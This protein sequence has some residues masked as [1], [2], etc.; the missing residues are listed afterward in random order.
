MGTRKFKVGK[1]KLKGW[2]DKEVSKAIENRKR[3]NR[4]QRSLA[5]KMKKYGKEYEKDWREAW[6]EYTSTKKIAQKVI[7]EKIGRWEKEQA[8]IL[9]TLPRRE[10]EK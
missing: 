8:Q 10:R 1:T 5:K 9:N 4:K 7:R 2:W 3:A 6:I